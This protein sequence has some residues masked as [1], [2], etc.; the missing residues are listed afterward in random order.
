MYRNSKHKS[1]LAIWTIHNALLC[2]P[3]MLKSLVVLFLGFGILL[4]GAEIMNAG[5]PTFDALFLR[6][7]VGSNMLPSGARLSSCLHVCEPSTPTQSQQVQ[8]RR[9]HS[10]ESCSTANLRAFRT[11]LAWQ[12]CDECSGASPLSRRNCECCG[13]SSAS[14][15]SARCQRAPRRSIAWPM[16]ASENEWH[17]PKSRSRVQQ[18]ADGC[19]RA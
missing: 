15:R 4:P 8:P 13:H 18:G 5:C 10:G 2:Y 17:R 11:V 12:G 1:W 19:A 3:T 9:A 14:A 16:T 6:G 7:K